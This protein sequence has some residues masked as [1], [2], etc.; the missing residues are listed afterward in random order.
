MV[1]ALHFV[2]CMTDRKQ[3][4]ITHAILLGILAI[5]VVGA[6]VSLIQQD[7]GSWQIGHA[8]ATLVLVFALFYAG[9]VT[10]AVALWGRRPGSVLGIHLVGIAAVAL[11][12]AANCVR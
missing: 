2:R 11:F 10:V 9:M 12:T 8:F 7:I 1:A 4:W 3:A 6:V 5:P